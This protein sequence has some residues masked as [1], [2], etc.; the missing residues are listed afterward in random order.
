MQSRRFSDL[1]VQGDPRMLDKGDVFDRYEH[2]NKVAGWFL[3]QS[4]EWR[5][6]QG[7]LAE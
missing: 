5:E 3:G 7:W 1:K 2:A 6:C 4:H